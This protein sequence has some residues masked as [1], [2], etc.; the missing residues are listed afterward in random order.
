MWFP[1]LSR[2]E[3]M[4]RVVSPGRLDPKG[5]EEG[6]FPLPEV[7]GVDVAEI[8]QHGQRVVGPQQEHAL[9]EGHVLG[10]AEHADRLQQL[11]AIPRTPPRATP[12]KGQT[13]SSYNCW[14]R[15]KARLQ[16]LTTAGQDISY[17][18]G[19]VAIRTG[20][21]LSV[22]V[23]LCTR[24]AVYLSHCVPVSL[25]TSPFVHQSRCVPI[26]LCTNPIVYQPHCVPIPLCTNP[27]V[28]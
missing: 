25:C 18:K 19:R 22:P 26:P 27:I 13:L 24:P 2:P 10:L 23:P 9:Q 15:Q 11:P 5:A 17:V 21:C 16:V 6:A 12:A 1:W 4:D 3:N 28:Y 8:G 20:P 14:T 7:P